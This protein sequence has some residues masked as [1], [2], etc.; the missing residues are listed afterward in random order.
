MPPK[1]SVT[2]TA[3]PPFPPIDPDNYVVPEDHPDSPA[4]VEQHTLT[5]EDYNTL[6]NRYR[7]TLQQVQ[8][9]GE[10]LHAARVSSSYTS[11]PP[12][13]PTLYV[14]RMN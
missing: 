9:L 8:E 10:A 3:R 14:T 12:E 6:V 5:R 4:S 13:C 11:P 7:E 2:S 1:K